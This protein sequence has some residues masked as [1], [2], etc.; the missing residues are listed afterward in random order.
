MACPTSRMLAAMA[1]LSRPI[2]TTFMI[3]SSK[4]ISP[5]PSLS[6]ASN[7]ACASS[8][9]DGP[10]TS[11]MSS[12]YRASFP[13]TTNDIHN[14]FAN[15][16]EDRVFSNASTTTECADVGLKTCLP[17]ISE[18]ILP[19]IEVTLSPMRPTSPMIRN[20]VADPLLCG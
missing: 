15:A 3:I 11:S 12:W 9:R 10:R 1:F 2:S 14:L 19:N 7:E 5:F 16:S 17:V 6:S 18:A 13:S 8:F 20:G 4:L